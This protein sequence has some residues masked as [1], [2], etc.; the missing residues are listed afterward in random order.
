MITDE[1]YLD[2]LEVVREYNAQEYRKL[3]YEKG[4]IA[5]GL[6]D[7]VPAR[8]YKETGEVV[9]IT[10]NF[11]EHETIYGQVKTHE[12]YKFKPKT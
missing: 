1:E 2:A 7:N 9:T 5:I 3:P 8:R 4:T 12:W 11:I 6:F 10:K